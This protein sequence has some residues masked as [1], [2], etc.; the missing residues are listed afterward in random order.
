MHPLVEKAQEELNK[1]SPDIELSISYIS[2]AHEQGDIEATYALATWYLHGKYLNQDTILAR[3]LLEKAAK[4]NYSPALFD[5]AIM[6]EKS[7]SNK[8]RNKK[9]AFRLYVK[10]ALLGDVDS[11][12]EVARCYYYGIGTKKNRELADVWLKVFENLKKE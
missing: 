9:E 8:I 7:N 3:Q 10:S 12:H 6:I 1:T 4:A 11:Y 2:E 5:L